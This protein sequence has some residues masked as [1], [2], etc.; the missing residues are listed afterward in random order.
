MHLVKMP[1]RQSG[2]S[3]GRKLKKDQ[4]GARFANTRG[5]DPAKPKHVPSAAKR[6]QQVILSEGD[7]S[8]VTENSADETAERDSVGVM[9]NWTNRCGH[10]SIAA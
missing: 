9:T 1:S 8:H 2:A 5:G 4:S 3:A 7:A 6:N 10:A